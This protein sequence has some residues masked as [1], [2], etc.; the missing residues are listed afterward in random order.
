MQY[1]TDIKRSSY[2]ADIPDLF[3]SVSHTTMSDKLRRIGQT[4]FIQHLREI[5]GN[6]RFVN[7]VCDAGSIIYF[8]VIDAALSHPSRSSK[9]ILLE[10]YENHDWNADQYESFLQKTVTTLLPNDDNWQQEVY[11]IL[12]ANLPA[13]VAGLLHF[14]NDKE[15]QG[16]GIM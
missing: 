2:D 5:R 1:G 6:T 12:C 3:P 4:M 14:I 15:G 16:A 9:V 7:L 11:G 8:K 13:Q 10:P